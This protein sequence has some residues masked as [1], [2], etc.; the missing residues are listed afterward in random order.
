MDERLATGERGHWSATELLGV[1]TGGRIEAGAPADLVTLDTTSPRT[2][3]T[4]ADE[5]TAVFAATAADVVQVTVDGRVVFR[6][7]DEQEIG[8]ELDE[9]IG[10]LWR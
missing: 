5:H 3:G 10:A 7:G 8:R 9:A 2:A 6:K 1:G 4:G